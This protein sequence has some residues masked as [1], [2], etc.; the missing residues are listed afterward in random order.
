MNYAW[1]F[2]S[3]LG[4]TAGLMPLLIRL[5]QTRNWLAVP[6]ERSSHALPTPLGG[7]WLALGLPLLCLPFAALMLPD[8]WRLSLYVLAVAGLALLVVSGINDKIGLKPL[9]RLTLHLAAAATAVWSLPE[10]V[11]VFPLLPELAETVILTL[12]LVWFVNLT[13]FI[14]GIDGIT[15]VNGL[16]SLLGFALLFALAGAALFLPLSAALLGGA[17][18]GFLLWNWHPAPRLSRRCRQ[19]PARPLAGYGTHC[20]GRRFRPARSPASLSL[21]SMR[22]QLDVAAPPEKPRKNLAGP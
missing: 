3:M 21:P 1:L 13:N 4:L 15:A 22:C 5:L 2:L 10:T 19:R 9:W 14:D 12:G 8:A 18:L 11:R 16:S 17:L 20:G 7:G 6:N